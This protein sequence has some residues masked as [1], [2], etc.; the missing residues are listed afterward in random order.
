MLLPSSCNSMCDLL[1]CFSNSAAERL[2][3]PQNIPVLSMYSGTARAGECVHYPELQGLE[4]HFQL[5]HHCLH[6]APG[7]SAG[8]SPLAT[9]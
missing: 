2:S 3:Q 4:H 5:L 9:P 1:L 8:A 6:P 7:L